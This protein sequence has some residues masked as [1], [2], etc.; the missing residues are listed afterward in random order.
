MTDRPSSN[1]QE[2]VLLTTI[3]SAKSIAMHRVCARVFVTFNACACSFEYRSN[4]LNSNN[5]SINDNDSRRYDYCY[6]NYFK[7]YYD[8][9]D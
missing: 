7:H 9:Y 2:T 8:Y 1:S 3:C 6:N 5:M 4:N